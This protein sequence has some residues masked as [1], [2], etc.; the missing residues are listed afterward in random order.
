MPAMDVLKRDFNIGA[1]PWSEIDD[2]VRTVSLDDT[3]SFGVD[4]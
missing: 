4:S 2:A 1:A 3:F